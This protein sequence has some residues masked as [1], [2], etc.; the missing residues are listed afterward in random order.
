MFI[1]KLYFQQHLPSGPLNVIMNNY[2]YKMN[3]E[4]HNESSIF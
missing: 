1:K 3:D 2:L 4:G